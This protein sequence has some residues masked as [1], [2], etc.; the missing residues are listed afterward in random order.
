M[1]VIFFMNLK[2]LNQLFVLLHRIY[3]KT[4]LCTSTKKCRFPTNQLGDK[5]H[6][7]TEEYKLNLD[8]KLILIV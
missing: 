4:I 5:L 2:L 7:T 1:S 6:N 8:L 3:L